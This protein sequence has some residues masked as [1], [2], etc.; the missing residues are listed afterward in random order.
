MVWKI[1]EYLPPS[2]LAQ[3][4]NNFE[5]VIVNDGADQETRKLVEAIDSPINITYIEMPRQ[6]LCQSIGLLFDF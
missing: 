4:W 2:I 1:S 6:G 5:W 3:N